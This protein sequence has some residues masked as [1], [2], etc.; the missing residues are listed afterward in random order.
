MTKR[1]TE[2]VGKFS[3]PIWTGIVDDYENVNTEL[4]NLIQNLK[5]QNPGGMQKSNNLGWHSP[6]LDLN[7]GVIKE[8]FLKISPMVKEVSQDMC[9]DLKNFKIK[10]INCWS[11]V[12]KKFA[13][14]AGHIHANSLIS[15]AYYI[16]ADKNCGKIVFDD[17]RPGASIK[18]GPYSSLG[19]WNQG[20]VTIEP[21][22]GLLVMFPS[23]LV[24]HVQPNMSDTERVIL[25]FNID[26][27]RN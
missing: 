23:Y 21:K 27:I 5:K 25:S 26:I 10:V 1:T 13:S 20:N 17:P 14:N 3:T 24:H 2:V 19:N 18:K 16:N 6:D 15:S 11:I 12:N 8:F 22:N 4:F 9:W 7:N